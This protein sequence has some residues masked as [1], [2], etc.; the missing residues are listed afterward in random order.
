MQCK[1]SIYV[2]DVEL[3]IEVM[4]PLGIGY[5]VKSDASTECTAVFMYELQH[6][7]SHSL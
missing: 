7:V 6:L 1:L 4:V 5:P 2:T 3:T